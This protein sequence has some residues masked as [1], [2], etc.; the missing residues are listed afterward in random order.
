LRGIGGEE[1]REVVTY[2]N[3]I[4]ARLVDYAVNE[5][6]HH[7]GIQGMCAVAQVIANRVNS[8]WGE[9]KKVI[10]DAHN[11]SGT[12]VEPPDLDPKDLTF[13]RMLTMVDDIYYGTADDT[14]VNIEDDRGKTLALYYAELNSIDRQWFSDNITGNIDMH[15]RLATVGPLTFFG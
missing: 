8:G 9:W 12:I 2:E 13:R 11:Y 7:G 10:D 4:K 3:Y 6:Y 1:E 15:P 14:N 5:A